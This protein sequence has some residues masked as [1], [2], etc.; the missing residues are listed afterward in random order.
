MICHCHVKLKLSWKRSHEAKLINETQVPKDYT[1]ASKANKTRAS[2]LKAHHYDPDLCSD[3]F[4]YLLFIYSSI[5]FLIS[6]AIVVVYYITLIVIRRFVS[7]S[8]NQKMMSRENWITK[9]DKRKIS[10][11]ALLF[12]VRE[13]VKEENK[14]QEGTRKPVIVFWLLIKTLLRGCL[15]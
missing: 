5:F 13:K 11:S 2:R 10:I 4:Y 8:E 9:W 15:I 1:I 12:H 6:N 7:V 3:Y 14:K